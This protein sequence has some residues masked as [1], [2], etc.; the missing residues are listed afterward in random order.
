MIFTA[1]LTADGTPDDTG[2]LAMR[3][4][5]RLNVRMRKP[6][7]CGE[8]PKRAEM[9]AILGDARAAVERI[10]GQSQVQL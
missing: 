10:N 5:A 2:L 9:L 3:S 4:F 6:R 8:H 7:P 1:N